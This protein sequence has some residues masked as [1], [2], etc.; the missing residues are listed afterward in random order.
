MTDQSK[1]VISIIGD[2][3]V[4]KSTL[5]SRYIYHTYS[6]KR[7]HT[8]GAEFYNIKLNDGNSN[9]EI[10]IKD[11]A[12]EERHRNVSRMFYITADAIILVFDLVEQSSLD[13]AS[14][15]WVKEI[16]SQCAHNIPVILVGNKSDLPNI[17]RKYVA[18]KVKL[19]EQKLNVIQYY[20]TS[21]KENINVDNAFTTVTNHIIGKRQSC[22]EHETLLLETKERG[23]L[24]CGCSCCIL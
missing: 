19:I 22:S 12:G 23:C 1:F 11:T 2:S 17:N 21:A 24:F 13:N 3:G 20:E 9:L 6:S 10:R 14:I 18:E 7:R 8:L 16:I 4:G 15:D 5:I